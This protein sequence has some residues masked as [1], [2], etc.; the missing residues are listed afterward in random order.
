MEKKKVEVFIGCKIGTE[1]Y[2]YFEEEATGDQIVE[3]LLSDCAYA[4]DEVGNIIPGDLCIWY[5][6]SNEKFGE[7]YIKDGSLEWKWEWG[8][9]ESNFEYVTKF[10]KRLLMQEV[11]TKE[12]CRKLMDAIEIGK[13]IGDMYE[14]GNY[15]EIVSAGKRW[16]PKITHTK[17]HMKD[18]IKTVCGYFEEKGMKVKPTIEGRKESGP[19]DIS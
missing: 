17:Q 15:L 6:G 5:L 7:L 4:H 16:I 12:Q 1:N 18:L 14:I 9:G 11:I 2:P 13:T 3:H 8:F 19:T 10:I